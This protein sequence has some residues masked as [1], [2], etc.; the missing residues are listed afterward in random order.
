MRQRDR[1]DEHAIAYMR[2]LESGVL[3]PDEPTPEAHAEHVAA[4]RA[5]FT[6]AERQRI[7]FALGLEEP[8]L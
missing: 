5:Q 1:M 4:A 7:R 3:D 2:L 6:P 8:K